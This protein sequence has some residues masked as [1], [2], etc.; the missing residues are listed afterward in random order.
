MAHAKADPQVILQK[1]GWEITL[2]PHQVTAVNA[3]LK[4]EDVLV[5]LPTGYGKSI[6]YI[7]LPAVMEQVSE[8]LEEHNMSPDRLIF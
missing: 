4:G 8:F 5:V 2:K 7:C 6:I 1:L 3:A